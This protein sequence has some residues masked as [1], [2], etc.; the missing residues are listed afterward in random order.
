M[1][2]RTLLHEINARTRG[3]EV[4][5]RRVS[6]LAALTTTG[7]ILQRFCSE[8]GEQNRHLYHISYYQTEQ[9]RSM[10]TKGLPG[11]ITAHAAI[12][13]ATDDAIAG[14]ADEIMTPSNTVAAYRQAMRA[15]TPLTS[16]LG[17]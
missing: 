8:R 5:T 1:Q 10:M 16:Q 9:R 17:R 15:C 11:A 3:D 13:S 6:A 14:R 12:H 7:T 4:M 2:D